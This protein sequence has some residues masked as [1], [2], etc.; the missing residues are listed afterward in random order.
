MA[1]G[2]ADNKRQAARDGQRRDE[3]VDEEVA[4]PSSSQEEPS[5]RHQDQE[6]RRVGGREEANNIALS[7]RTTAR[8]G[9]NTGNRERQGASIRSSVSVSLG[10]RDSIASLLR[11][12]RARYQEQ[13]RVKV[14]IKVLPVVR[15]KNPSYF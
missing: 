6:E 14:A 10:S 12:R 15:E 7:S 4:G 8:G 9:G 5:R 2:K 13:N 3:D 1:P 11:E